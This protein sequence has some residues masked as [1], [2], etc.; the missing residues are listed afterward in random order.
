[1]RR[2]AWIIVFV[3]IA[4]CVEAQDYTG[5]YEIKAVDGVIALS[6]H[7]SAD[8]SVAGTLKLGEYVMSVSGK[9][10]EAGLAGTLQSELETMGFVAQ[11]QGDTLN[12]NVFG[13]DDM[14][15]P[16]FG[17]AQTL[18][19]RE[20]HKSQP[21]VDDSGSTEVAIN[22]TVLSLE[23]VEALQ[24][25][26]QTKIPPGRF[27]YDAQSGAWGM[28]GGPTIGFIAAGLDLPG[29]MPADISAG[30]TGIFINGREIHPQDQMALYALLGATYPGRYWLDAQGNL[31]IEGGTFLVNLISASQ[32]QAGAKGGLYSGM[33]G[34]VGVDGSGGV[35]FYSK[36]ASGGYTTWNN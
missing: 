31:G 3:A 33:G 6:L 32:Q 19:F 26:Y 1:M 7:Q 18:P 24:Q 27:W 21:G 2:A 35:L 29:P 36:N 28:Q 8:G 23:K 16:D 15:R 34:T 30:G 25:Q 4:A 17:G 9:V 13:F 5:E 10:E 11:R 14:G 20:K 12:L 22:G